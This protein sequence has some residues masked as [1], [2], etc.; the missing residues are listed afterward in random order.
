MLVSKALTMKGAESRLLPCSPPALRSSVVPRGPVIHCGGG[1]THNAA[2][3]RNSVE[4]AKLEVDRLGESEV[5][6]LE[7]LPGVLKKMKGISAEIPVT[8]EARAE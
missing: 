8:S 5:P 2:S 7:K 1:Q 6:V 4:D 3:K